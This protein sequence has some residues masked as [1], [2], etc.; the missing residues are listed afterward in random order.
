MVGI[1]RELGLVGLLALSLL[2]PSVAQAAPD[3]QGGG[4]GAQCGS[5]TNGRTYVNVDGN[6]I[7]SPA[8]CTTGTVPSGATAQC[9]DGT[10]SFSQ[11]AQG[12]CSG[13]GGVGLSM[14]P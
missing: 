7:H 5:L 10:Y 13:H 3:W 2:L 1:L 11:H 4:A 8:S 12:S 6:T 9:G 14:A